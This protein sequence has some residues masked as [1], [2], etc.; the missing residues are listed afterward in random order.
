MIKK[1]LQHRGVGTIFEKTSRAAISHVLKADANA[2]FR[3]TTV[4]VSNHTIDE[5]FVSR[6]CRKG[7]S[8]FK[9]V[10]S[11][12]YCIAEH[13]FLKEIEINYIININ[14]KPNIGLVSMFV[15]DCKVSS[16]V[17]MFS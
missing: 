6:T 2:N 5:T 3:K 8:K 7:I 17:S 1:I 11:M 13:I 16:L 14:F 10:V 4:S 9:V 12:F 15:R